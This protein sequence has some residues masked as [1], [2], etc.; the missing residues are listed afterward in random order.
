MF[1][2][3]LGTGSPMPD[4]NRAGPATLVQTAGQN[5]LF[6]AG[7]G[8]FHTDAAVRRYAQR[9]RDIQ[10]DGRVGLGADHAA[11]VG[12]VVEAVGHSLEPAF[13]VL[14]G[15]DGNHCNPESIGK[16]TF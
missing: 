16:V 14:I 8:V 7:R 2:T 12:D 1:V 3:T 9:R 6:D 5:L 13:R 4:P 10:E 15:E 11:G